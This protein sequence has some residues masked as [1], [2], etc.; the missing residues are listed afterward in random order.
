VLDARTDETFAARQQETIYTCAHPGAY[1]Y[2][3]LVV[4]RNNGAGEI[5]L[6]ELRLFGG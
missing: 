6:A 1:R 4:R 2:Y 3:R 5:Q